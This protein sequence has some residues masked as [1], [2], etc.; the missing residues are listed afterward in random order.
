[1]AFL[2]D[3]TS[4]PAVYRLNANHW[5]T[6]RS[7]QKFVVVGGGWWWLRVILVL[8]FREVY[9]HILLFPWSIFSRWIYNTFMGEH[10]PIELVVFCQSLTFTD[11][12]LLC[13]RVSSHRLWLILVDRV[14]NKSH[15]SVLYFTFWVKYF[16]HYPAD[17][18]IWGGEYPLIFLSIV[19]KRM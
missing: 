11:R 13:Q 12:F 15:K 3:T 10:S 4:L 2:V 6:A 5:N 18:T 7:C 14:W 19:Y 16:T 9:K 8:S 17:N 1:M